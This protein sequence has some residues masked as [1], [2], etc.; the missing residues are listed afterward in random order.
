MPQQINRLII[1]FAVLIGGLI[2]ARYLLVPETFGDIGHYR[3][4]AIDSVMVQ[5]IRYAGEQICAECHDEQTEAKAD[6]HHNR[7]ACE[8]C[9]GASAAHVEDP[10]AYIP[11]APRDRGYCTLCHGY[12]ASRPTGFPQI[13][14]MVH[15]PMKPC[16]T[17]HNPHDPLTPNVPESCSA[18]HGEIARTKAVSHHAPLACIQ[19]HETDEAHKVTPH[20]VRAKKP[21]SRSLCGGCHAKGA[22]SPKVIPR[23]RM[24]DHGNGYVCWQCH[25]PHF[26][27]VE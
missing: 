11:L 8:V 12:N 24:E 3:A 2:T 21:T 6:S 27:E 9:H 17:C 15:N 14:P 23:I 13:D 4:S 25:Y 18:C 26:P 22:D 20:L 19:C 10:E 5:P 7:V 1:I 16:V